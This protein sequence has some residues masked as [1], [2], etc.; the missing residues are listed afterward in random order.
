[1]EINILR[2]AH[3]M[4]TI[5]TAFILSRTSEGASDMAEDEPGDAVQVA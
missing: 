5:T 3:I 1:L 2:K 4:T